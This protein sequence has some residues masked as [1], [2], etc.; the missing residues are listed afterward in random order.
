[1]STEDILHTT[2]ELL[3]TTAA[4]W[5]GLADAVAPELLLRAPAPG[6]WSVAD[7]LRHL[8]ASEQRVLSVR[9]QHFMEGRVELT[10]MAEAPQEP[11]GRSPR[12]L[13]AAFAAERR[14]T[15]AAFARIGAED[16]ERAAYH[17]AFDSTVTLREL[18]NLWAAHDLQH[19]VQ[20]EEALMQAF[21]PGT[22][23]W[24]AGFAGH[25]VQARTAG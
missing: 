15:V 3:S 25:D 7:C 11:E 13:A 4:R 21:I 2:R 10:P 20:A 23:V 12:E 18:L 1:V 6:E 5:Q 9:L 8:L 17:P 22:G 19:T 16:L 14:R 24:R